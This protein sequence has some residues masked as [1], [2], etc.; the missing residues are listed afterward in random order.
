MDW[1]NDFVLFEKDVQVSTQSA[2][3]NMAYGGTLIDRANAEQDTFKKKELLT[4]AIQHLELAVALY[5]DTLLQVDGRDIP[6]G[7]A[8]AYNLLGNAYYTLNQDMAKAEQ[9][10][11]MAA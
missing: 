5:G 7:Y 11:K 3:L 1:E 2:K 8:N 10:Y 4:L 9:A 6:V